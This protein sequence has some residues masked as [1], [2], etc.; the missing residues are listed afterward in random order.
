M[1]TLTKNE[2]WSRGSDTRSYKG[3]AFIKAIAVSLASGYRLSHHEFYVSLVE[4]HPRKVSSSQ[5]SNVL[6]DLAGWLDW[7]IS[8]CS[9][10]FLSALIRTGMCSPIYCASS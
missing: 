4:R 10:P 8:A 1:D 5:D 7:A 3:L 6:V 2:F 9:S